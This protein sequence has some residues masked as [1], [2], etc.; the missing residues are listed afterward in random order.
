MLQRG[1]EP[2]SGSDRARLQIARATLGNPPLLLL[3]HVDFDLGPEGCEYWRTS[4][5]PIRR[6]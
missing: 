4:F 3:N 6:S 5:G 2:L 1:G